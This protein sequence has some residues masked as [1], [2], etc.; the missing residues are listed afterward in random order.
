MS[1]KDVLSNK[2]SK[3]LAELY[4]KTQGDRSWFCEQLDGHFDDIYEV[5]KILA[6]GLRNNDNTE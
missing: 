6:Q 3:S 1:N 5:A 2:N 4:I